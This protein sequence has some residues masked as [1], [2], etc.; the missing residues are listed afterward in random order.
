MRLGEFLPARR[1]PATSGRRVSMCSRHGALLA[2]LHKRL[3]EIAAPPDLGADGGD[4]LLHLDLHPENVVLGAAGPVVVDWT[5]A[6]GGDPALD[7]ALTW[8]I[9]ATSAG[10][11]GRWFLRSFLPHFDAEELQRALPA[12]AERRLADP[13]VTDRERDAVLRL[14]RRNGA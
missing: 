6:R 8:I 13:N 11:P 10:L 3:H 4:R 1:W 9:L 14:L 12:A 7:V 5:N 2:E